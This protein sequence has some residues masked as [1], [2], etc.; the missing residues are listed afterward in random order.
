MAILSISCVMGTALRFEIDGKSIDLSPDDMEDLYFTWQKWLQYRPFLGRVRSEDGAVLSRVNGAVELVRKV[1]EP[2]NGGTS[3][4]GVDL[5]VRTLK[6]LHLYASSDR[7]WIA[8]SDAGDGDPNVGL[9]FAS[10]SIGAIP[11]DIFNSDAPT[12]PKIEL[13]RHT[14]SPVLSDNSTVRASA[15]GVI[16]HAISG[17]MRSEGC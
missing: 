3:G 2:V 16:P 14:H 10:G 11:I 1:S 17:S 6:S 15:G 4:N 9:E 13:N 8:P 7:L 5:G 12:V